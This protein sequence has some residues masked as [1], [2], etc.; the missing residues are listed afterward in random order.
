MQVR[1]S[2]LC[3][4][5][6]V[7]VGS[8]GCGLRV[9]ARSELPQQSVEMNLIG[10]NR[11]ELQQWKLKSVTEYFSPGDPLRSAATRDYSKILTFP[12]SPQVLEL[13]DTLWSKWSARKAEYLV[14]MVNIPGYS[15]KDDK[16]GDGDPRRII[17]PLK[18]DRWEWSYWGPL[19]VELVI[20]SGG[21]SCETI[22]TPKDD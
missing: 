2:L 12:P 3:M 14:V 13:G 7:L 11:S 17:L 4:M 21:V 22:Y 15:F 16:P 9:N 10:V 1:G 19:T 18:L 6:L 8:A 20:R 5:L